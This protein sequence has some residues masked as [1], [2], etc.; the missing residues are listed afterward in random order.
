MD[1]VTK[2]ELMARIGKLQNHLTAQGIDLAVLNMNSDLYYY[3]GSVE[4]LYL[5]IPA[6]GQ[7]V[8][9]A[10]KAIQRIRDEASHIKLEPFSGTKDL[11]RIISGYGYSGARKVGMTLDTTAYATVQRWRQLFTEADLVDLSWDIRVLRMVKSEIE[12]AVLTKAGAIMAGVPDLVKL[13]F[14]PGMTELQLSAM[15]ENYFRLN[16][17]GVVVRCR[18]E[19]IEMGFGV[20]SSGVNTLA[21]TKFDGICAGVGI[22]TA[23]P[24][25]ANADPIRRGVPIL[26]D[27]AFNLE[28]YH[29]DQT[30]MFSWTEPVPEVRRAY[31]AMLQVEERVIML[32]KPG[33]LWTEIYDEA[34]KLATELGYEKEFMGLGPE[35]VKFVGHGVGLELDEPPFLAPKNDY[36]LEA[37]MVVAVEPKVSLP[38]IGVVGIEDTLVIRAEKAE[39]LTTVSREFFILDETL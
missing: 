27:Y 35:K 10:R 8:L 1:S 25:G 33:R 3:S 7:A 29:M 15:V 14:K 22:S 34:L 38:D 39:F 37:G 32:L 21:G 20:C 19:G 31:E 26:L 28:G 2:N 4:P 18:R 17:H 23:V 12:I 30:R 36:P 5:I 16:H 24:Y 9:L 6:V 13:N 11:V